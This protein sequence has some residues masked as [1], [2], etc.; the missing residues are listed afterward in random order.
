MAEDLE[1]I[2]VRVPNSCQQICL[3]HFFSFSQMIAISLN[4]FLGVSNAGNPC[5]GIV[6]KRS[7]P[8]LC[9]N[10]SGSVNIPGKM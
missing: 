3:D 9:W 6:L 7:S 4:L 8:N 2:E 10:K 5:E 1:M